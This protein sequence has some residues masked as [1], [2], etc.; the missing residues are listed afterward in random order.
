[1]LKT[2]LKGVV[3]LILATVFLISSVFFVKGWIETNK[4][5]NDVGYNLPTTFF[6][7]WYHSLKETLW[8][9]ELFD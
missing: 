3:S 9:D 6:K 8:E 2:V 1:M 7:T 4:I 5:L